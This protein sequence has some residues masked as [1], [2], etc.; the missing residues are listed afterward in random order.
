VSKTKFVFKCENHGNCNKYSSVLRYLLDTGC[1]HNT[2]KDKDDI[3]NLTNLFK[4]EVLRMQYTTGDFMNYKLKGKL[5]SLT[6][7]RSII[8]TLQQIF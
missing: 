5:K 2:V 4:N 6:S 8:R 1:T 7:K 3:I